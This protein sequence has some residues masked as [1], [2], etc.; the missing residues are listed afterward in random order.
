MAKNSFHLELNRLREL[1]AGFA[2][3]N[4][5]LA[6]FLNTYMTDPDV[7]RLLDAVAH[8]NRLLDRK[9][10][11]DFPGLVQK[12]A[13]LML[14]HY[15]R[16]IPA[17]TIVTFTPQY[18]FDR[19]IHISAGTQIDSTP[20]NGTSCRFTTSCDLEVHPVELL[21][22]S[23]IQ[24]SVRAAEIRMIFTLQGLALSQWQPGRLR[25]FLSGDRAIAME[26]YALFCQNITGIVVAAA[27]GGACVTLPPEYLKQSG[28]EEN[29]ALIPYPTHT[30][31]GY[32]LLQ[33]YFNAPEK[34]LFLELTGLECWENRGDGCQFTVSFHLDG[35]SSGL[36]RVGRS[37]FVLNAVPAINIFP[38]EADPV[39]LDH[40]ASS[41]LVRP[42]GPNSSGCQ[43]LS[44]DGVT[45]F[46]R[47]T[48]QERRYAAFELFSS[49]SLGN[50]IY[51]ASLEKS[52]VRTGYDVF[53]SVSFPD[54]T[55][56]PTVET[57][58][59]A[60]TCTNGILPGQLRIG[61]ICNPVSG[62]FGNVSVRNITPVNP[63][64][65]PSFGS[66]LLWRLTCHLYL[67]H[68]SL[69]SAGNLT[70]L[71]KLYAYQEDSPGSMVTANLK[72]IDGIEEVSV[73]PGESF[74]SGV[75]MMGNEIHLKVRQD[76]FAG[77][78]DMYLFGCILDRFLGRYASINY[79]TWLIMDEILRGERMLWPMRQE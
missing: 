56:F 37:S 19:S 7:E 50:P 38:H 13:N 9:L 16:P 66:E 17:T 44:V 26:L 25:F 8:Q 11:V 36:P 64:V 29:E 14:P 45:G 59:I 74:V 35:L 58:S 23:I 54:G 27:E 10:G 71:L 65:P 70:T 67:N 5:A 21:D 1:A 20:V 49:E 79:Y 2:D 69:A 75:K 53:L 31:P 72:R 63:G 18:S 57:L 55:Y 28:F 34:F 22:T 30:F 48:G 77:T 52:L 61:D 51:Q 33:E 3:A 76:C 43:I 24:T 41:Y 47:E 39:H 62:I 6:P 42:S 12:L 78:G 46:S 68:M 4:P 60:L 40:R 15:V 32:R 73:V